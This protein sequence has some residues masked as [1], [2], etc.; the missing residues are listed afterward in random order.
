MQ[1]CKTRL[2][3]MPV[4]LSNKACE[5][6]AENAHCAMRDHNSN[7]ATLGLH[8]KR[9]LPGRYAVRNKGKPPL[10]QGNS[11][12]KQDCK[13]AVNSWRTTM[14]KVPKRSM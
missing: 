3:G 6:A 14:F 1:P 7:L 12:C 5:K 2:R 10:R 4:M 8:G 9:S 11:F 13:D